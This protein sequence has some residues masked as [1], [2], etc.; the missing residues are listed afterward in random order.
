[1]FKKRCVSVMYRFF[2]EIVLGSE[3]VFFQI[4]F[5]VRCRSLYGSSYKVLVKVFF[6]NFSTTLPKIL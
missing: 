5:R 3:I 6:L 4:C 1:V 2:F